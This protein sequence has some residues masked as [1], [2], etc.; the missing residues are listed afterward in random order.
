[1]DGQ[2]VIDRPASP[3]GPEGL[4][5]GGLTNGVTLSYAVFAIDGAGN[6][7]P[8]AAIEATPDV[9]QLPPPAQVQ[10]LHRTDNG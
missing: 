9:Q 3:G 8:V 7:S 4:T 2:G 10:N 5:H 6:V 1:M